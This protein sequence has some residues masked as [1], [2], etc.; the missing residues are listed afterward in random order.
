MVRAKS[1]ILNAAQ[2]T[3][4][5]ADRIPKRA[6]NSGVKISKSEETSSRSKQKVVHATL[7][8]TITDPSAIVSLMRY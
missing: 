6:N 4:R 8:G 5:L 3:L 2:K 1:T 7:P